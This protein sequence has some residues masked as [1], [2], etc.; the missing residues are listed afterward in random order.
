MNRK[1]ARLGE[2]PV[3]KLLIGLSMPAMI[4]MLVTALYNII[5]T[6]FVAQISTAAVAAVGIAFPVQLI[7]MAISNSIGIG[8]AA[9]ASQ[10]LGRKDLLGASRAYANVLIAVFLIS[11]L[12]ILSALAFLEPLLLLFGAT[13]AIMPYA[14]DFLS[15]TLLSAPF[16]M[17]TMA[18]SAMIRAEGQAS[19]QMKV[20]LTTVLINLVS[21]PLFIFVFG[22]GIKGAALGTALAQV[23]G[24]ILIFRFFFTKK[25]K[26]TLELGTNAFR[27]EPALVS[28]MM[29]IGSSSFIMQV[30]QSVLFILVNHML[31]RHGGT[32]EIAT[33]AIINKFMA[34]VGMPIMGIVQGMQPIVGFN[35]GSRQF[36]RMSDAIKLA[37]RY[38]LTV[39]LTLW[40]L[41][42]LFPDFWIGMFTR[43]QELLDQGV[44]AMRI[45]F[46]ISFVYGAQMIINGMYQ[47]L[48]KAKAALFLSL[49]R[50]TL[51]TIPLVLLL[52]SFLGVTGVWIAFPL[53]DVMAVSTAFLFA[54]RDRVML[55]K[56]EEYVEE[57]SQADREIGGSR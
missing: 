1:T 55:F 32:T 43:D 13:D 36:D 52:P 56:P 2:E 51:Y 35:F 57:E 11:T 37:L 29:Q 40:L 27:F 10:R 33:F 39:S 3:K 44:T 46:A 9:L 12:A 23:I 45:L 6:I 20:M 7:L 50:Q 48:G 18:S 28:R 31:V 15:I 41:L 38:G 5:D 14:K 53:A 19:F 26:T 17:L 49:S 25:R 21:T 34:L 30:S 54:Y 22:L 4:G 47:S 16:F 8:G 42:Q 24:A